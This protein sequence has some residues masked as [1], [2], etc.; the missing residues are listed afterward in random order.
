MQTKSNEFLAVLLCG[1]KKI[2]LKTSHSEPISMMK[3]TARGSLKDINE[4]KEDKIKDYTAFSSI[5][6][7]YYFSKKMKKM[8]WEMCALSG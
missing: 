5:F 4:N 3:G 1:L 2:I 8:I 7:I 6:V